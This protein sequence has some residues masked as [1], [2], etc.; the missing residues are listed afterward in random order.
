[1]PRLAG[2]ALDA[3]ATGAVL[4]FPVL[5]SDS[6]IDAYRV[7]Y[8]NP[9]RAAAAGLALDAL[10]PGAIWTVLRE[11]PAGIGL[12]VDPGTEETLEF[13]PDEVDGVLGVGPGQSR[14]DTSLLSRRRRADLATRWVLLHRGPDG[15]PVGS[16]ENQYGSRF[17]FA[18]TDQAAAT[19]ALS[20][21]NSLVQA[22]LASVLQGNPDLA[23]VLDPSSPGQLLIDAPLR[24]QV[25]YATGFFPKGYLAFVGELTPAA[26]KPVSK[27]AREL[28][29][30]LPALGAPV[31]GVWAVGYRLERAAAQI[32]LVIDVDSDEPWAELLPRIE[33]V[34]QGV[35][36]TVQE[37]VSALELSEIDDSFHD[38]IRRTR[39][40]VG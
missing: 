21:G 18:W 36:F 14:A 11:L 37:P 23:I 31:R 32:L 29:N 10:T 16:V 19:S 8:L 38:F 40:Y 28:A 20:P 1:M 27:G 24:E 7:A 34:M 39:N 33:Q 2:E 25:L 5:V 35:P 15:N 9:E 3:D 13:A 12:V 26:Q 22:P 6:V 17:V 4:D 30:R